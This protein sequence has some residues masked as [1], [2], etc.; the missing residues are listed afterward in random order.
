[1]TS[2]EWP[3]LVPEVVGS[4]TKQ[5]RGRLSSKGTARYL[6]TPEA[7]KYRTSCVGFLLLETLYFMETL[8]FNVPN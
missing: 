4:I 3:E 6:A 7:F 5:Q 1:M 2:G 8:Y